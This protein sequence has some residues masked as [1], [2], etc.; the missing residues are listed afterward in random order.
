MIG[1]LI[2]WFEAFVDESQNALWFQRATRC[3][4]LCR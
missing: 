3:R 2:G 1:G 4:P